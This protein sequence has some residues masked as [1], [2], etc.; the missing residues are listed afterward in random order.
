MKVKCINNNG[1][2]LP[3]GL[4]T[5]TDTSEFPITIGKESLIIKKKCLSKTKW[6]L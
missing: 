6:P 3:K 2:A 1:T 5:Y 4:Y